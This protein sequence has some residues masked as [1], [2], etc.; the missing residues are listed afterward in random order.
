MLS[1]SVVEPACI[2]LKIKVFGL[3][4]ELSS[5]SVF[6]STE[7]VFPKREPAESRDRVSKDI[8]LGEGFIFHN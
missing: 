1:I 7:S 2:D 5:S 3:L 8:F 4:K 6:K